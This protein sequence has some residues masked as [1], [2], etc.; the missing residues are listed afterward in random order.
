MITTTPRTTLVNF[1]TKNIK[2]DDHDYWLV[3]ALG[4]HFGSINKSDGKYFAHYH[5]RK[6]GLVAH[7]H[8]MQAVAE[9][10]KAYCEYMEHYESTFVNQPTF[11]KFGNFHVVFGTDKRMY[12][13]HTSSLEYFAIGHHDIYAFA[14]ELRRSFPM[15]MEVS[16]TLS[17]FIMNLFALIKCRE[18]A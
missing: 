8:Y 4:G 2:R 13:N 7:T 12:V 16:D 14:S 18:Y 5:N 11:Y 6:T 15:H 1:I 9:V 3:K 10:M 17:E